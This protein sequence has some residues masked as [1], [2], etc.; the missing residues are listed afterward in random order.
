LTV[1][2]KVLLRHVKAGSSYQG[3]NDLR[4]HFGLGAARMAE[5]LEIFW[6]SGSVDNLENVEANQ[7]LTISEGRGV[8]AKEP[9][10]KN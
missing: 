10:R 1:N 4:V 7:I 3:Q 8:T 5:R 2:G 6:P 9:F